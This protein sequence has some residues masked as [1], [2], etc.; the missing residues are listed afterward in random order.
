MR[1]KPKVYG[2][3]KSDIELQLSIRIF[4]LAQPIKQATAV[5]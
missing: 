4:E 3:Y 1:V 5:F 2:V